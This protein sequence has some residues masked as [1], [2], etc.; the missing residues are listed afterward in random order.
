MSYDLGPSWIHGVTETRVFHWKLAPGV[1]DLRKELRRLARHF[2]RQ[3]RAGSPAC[4]HPNGSHISGRCHWQQRSKAA[5]RTQ[6]QIAEQY[7]RLA[8]TRKSEHGRMANDLLAFGV[9]HKAEKLSYVAWQ[10]TFP[11][12]VRDRAPGLFVAIDRR[13]A[14]SA[15]GGLY[16]YVT[17]TTALSSTCPCGVRAKKPLH[18][19]RHRHVCPNGQTIDADRDLFSAFLGLY[20]YVSPQGRK[21]TLD[22]VGEPNGRSHHAGRTSLGRR[23]SRRRRKASA[24]PRL[25][26][27]CVGL[28]DDLWYGSSSVRGAMPQRRNP[29]E[30]FGANP[31]TCNHGRAPLDPRWRDLPAAVHLRPR[32]AA[33][34]SDWR[35]RRVVTPSASTRERF[36]IHEKGNPRPLG[37]GG[38]Q[39]VH[40]DHFKVMTRL[41]PPFFA[42]DIFQDG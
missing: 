30:G 39:I 35:Q 31:K 26:S 24:H 4:F 38:G 13:K 23:R 10:K 11:R 42:L 28:A 19:R 20:L 27:T 3:H 12:S 34:Q 14:A 41:W 6:Q 8:A 37:R 15:G 32:P 17:H 33:F 18:Q 22:L 9:F 36:S 2:D 25:E 1:A 16:E 29:T 21:D 7:R 40:S 5:V